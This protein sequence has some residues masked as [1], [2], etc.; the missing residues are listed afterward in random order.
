ME[1]LFVIAEP[2][3]QVG[4]NANRRLRR[5][6]R[7]PAT[8]YGRQLQA[9]SVA[10]DPKEI[11][12]ILH[13]ESGHNTIFKLKLAQ[14]QTDVLIRDIQLDP[15]SGQLL[16]ADFQAVAMDELMRFEVPVET[17][18]EARGVKEGGVL[19]TVL[20]EIEVECL[21]GDVP[22]NIAVDVS[23]LDIGDSLRVEDLQIGDHKIEIVSEPD[24]VVVTVVPPRVVEEEE[25]EV[26]EEAAEP[27]V[28]KKGK[29]EE[30]E[31][32]PQEESGS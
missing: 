11:F 14:N 18:G 13:S 10:V 8:F 26:E 17:L 4:K 20:R 21:P 16:H 9:V 1:E 12:R 5:A 15:V 28:I 3:D 25:P 22:E 24:L 7:I 31:E 30:E 29:A 23:E 19:D 6:G 32:E 27:E 2:R